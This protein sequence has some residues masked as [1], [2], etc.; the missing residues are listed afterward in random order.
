M[1]PQARDQAAGEE[2]LDDDAPPPPMDNNPSMGPLS[3]GYPLASICRSQTPR[4]AAVAANSS[5][6]SFRP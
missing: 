3:A 1:T 6:P 2:R 4:N 5:D